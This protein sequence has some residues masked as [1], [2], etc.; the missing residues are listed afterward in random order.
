MSA[1]PLGMAASEDDRAPR[2]AGRVGCAALLPLGV[3]QG[4]ADPDTEGPRH[5]GVTKRPRQIK[6]GD[7]KGR[8]KEDGLPAVF[9]RFLLSRTPS[10]GLR[11]KV[12][13]IQRNPSFQ[14]VCSWIDLELLIGPGPR[15]AGY[16]HRGAMWQIP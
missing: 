7:P 5:R 2:A 11:R 14:R 1:G 6:C 12:N 10:S 9:F 16:R 8:A 15:I 3:A 4:P 13:Q